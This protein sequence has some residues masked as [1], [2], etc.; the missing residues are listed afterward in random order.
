M[1][2]LKIK[3]QEEFKSAATIFLN[4]NWWVSRRV[5]S[6]GRLV[7][8]VVRGEISVCKHMYHVVKI[9]QVPKI[10]SSVS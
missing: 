2:K 5:I 6:K 4:L 3:V 9:F 8:F 1:S 7:G 10:K